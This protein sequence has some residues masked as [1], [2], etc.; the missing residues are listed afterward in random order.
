MSTKLALLCNQSKV[1][2]KVLGEKV[3]IIDSAW[4][5][6][7]HLSNDSLKKIW[8]LL[9]FFQDKRLIE[10]LSSVSRE[11]M[12]KLL[13]IEVQK[14]LLHNA[15]SSEIIGVHIRRGDYLA[16]PDY[17]VLTERYFVRAIQSL[18]TAESKIVLACDD[19]ETLRKLG[20]FKN[21]LLLY[22]ESNSPLS[23][24]ALLAKSQ[25]FIM[26]N[27]TFSF[28]VGWAVKQHGGSVYSPKPWFKRVKL[29]NDFLAL[30]GFIM[31]ES[32]FE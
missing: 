7:F 12:G 4:E 32:E 5:F 17:G 15:Q 13:G 25:F 14:P 3:V 26:S 1:L 10:N 20:S 29:P 21:Q 19:S 2:Q 18:S 23:T 31:L 11:F 24:M 27:S 6:P 9:G 30:D 28:W 22:P 8:V 16:I